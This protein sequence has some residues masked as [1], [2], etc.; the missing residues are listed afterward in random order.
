MA[1]LRAFLR[2]ARMERTTSRLAAGLPADDEI[3]LDA[4]DERLGPALVAAGRG[5]YGPAAELLATT[6]E[7]AE[8][9]S[10][11]RYATGLATFARSR[12]EWLRKWQ[13]ASPHD[14]DVLLVRAELAVRRA[15]ESPARVELL[16]QI[17]PLITAAAEGDPRDPVPWRIALDHARGTNVGHAEFEKLWGEAVRRSPHHYGCHVAALQYLSAACCDL[18]AACCASCEDTPQTS[19]RSHRECFD[20]AERAAQDALPGSLV[21]VLPVRAAFAYLTEG[22]GAAVPRERLD[23][24][25][26]LAIAVSATY[27]AVDPW[28]AEVRNLLAYVLIRLERWT[29]ALEQLRLIGPYATSFPWDR[30]SDDPL[31]RFLE[32]RDRVRLAAASGLPPRPPGP[33]PRPESGRDGRAHSAGH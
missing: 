14:P 22:G 10:R 6:R 8:W 9:E 13:A 15:W 16:R 21:Q 17:G 25:A 29:E 11:D 18:P 5:E 33:D 28:P 32:L 1:L 27:R 23:A 12:D 3:L 26:D 20:F 24:A 31:G 2:T 30:G 19:R 4:P 7:A